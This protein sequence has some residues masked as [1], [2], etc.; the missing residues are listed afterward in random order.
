MGY[1]RFHHESDVLEAFERLD[2]LLIAPAQ[3]RR[4][5]EAVSPFIVDCIDATGAAK[6]MPLKTC[7]LYRP[8]I[9]SGFYV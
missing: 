6:K 9:R 1:R 3:A 4:L 5:R 7:A 2:S 8:L